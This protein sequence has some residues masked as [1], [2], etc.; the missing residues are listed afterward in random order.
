MI[1]QLADWS[2]SNLNL[3]AIPLYLKASNKHLSPAVCNEPSGSASLQSV[4]SLPPACSR[5]WRAPWP[6]T[7][8]STST[9]SSPW[10]TWNSTRWRW[11]AST[12][13]TTRTWSSLTPPQR[14]PFASTGSNCC[15]RHRAAASGGSRTGWSQEEFWEDFVRLKRNRRCSETFFPKFYLKWVNDWIARWTVFVVLS[16]L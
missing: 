7:S 9:P 16:T 1:T 10:T 13:S 4:E 8:A 2:I 6:Q 3:Q 14:T 15:H 12:C 11:T 5:T